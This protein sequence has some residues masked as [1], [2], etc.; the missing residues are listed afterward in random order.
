MAPEMLE[1]FDLSQSSLGENL[2][3]EDIGH[4]LDSNTFSV[5]AIGGRAE[6]RSATFQTQTSF[7]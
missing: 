3:A 2:L 4:F 1:E 6:S 5:L 7:D